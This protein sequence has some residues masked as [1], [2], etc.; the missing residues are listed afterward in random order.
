MKIYDTN[1]V[2]VLTNSLEH[3]QSKQV[4]SWSSGGGR[5]IQINNICVDMID[6]YNNITIMV[7][8]L[9][10]IWIKYQV[11]YLIKILNANENIY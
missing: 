10:Q 3:I 11:D 6:I 8:I 1:Q 5:Y 2:L 9:Y 7:D 4:K